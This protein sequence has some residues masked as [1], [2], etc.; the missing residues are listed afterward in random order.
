MADQDQYRWVTPEELRDDAAEYVRFF[1]VLNRCSEKRE[2]EVTDLFYTANSSRMPLA[3]VGLA[4]VKPIAAQCNRLGMSVRIVTPT[5]DR[6]VDARIGGEDIAGS[7]S[8]LGASTR[9]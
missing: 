3:W 1:E 2:K 5:A 7:S 6:N 9:R 4:H 8:S